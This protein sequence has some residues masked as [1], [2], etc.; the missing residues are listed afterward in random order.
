MSLI[1][2]LRDASAPAVA[3]EIAAHRVSA[4]TLEIRGGQPVVAAHAAEPLLAGALIP[5]P[6]SANVLDRPA[7]VSAI[8]RLFERMGG[9]PRRVGLV[10]P[11]LVA[12]V[13]LVRLEQ[14]PTRALDREQL[15][16]WQVRKTLPFPIEEAQVTFVP[17][18]V[19]DEWHEFIVSIARRTVIEEYEQ[20]CAAVGAHAGLVDL[21]TFSVINAVLAGGSP[22]GDWLLLHVASDSASVAIVRGEH[23]IV[24]RCRPADDD[25]TLADV[26][27]QTAMYYEDRL[28]G[29]GFTRVLLAHAG[30]ETANVDEIRRGLEERLGVAVAIVDPRSAA[31]LTDRISANP[32]LLETLAPLV[33]LLLRERPVAHRGSA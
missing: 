17:G 3:I 9:R 11:D 16:R 30:L 5:S 12:K 23:L 13:S 21:S 7:V 20:L 6:T 8:G 27:H 25:V 22:G 4:A 28:K 32:V 19:T 29:S 15:V 33:G 26:V 2:A 18:L 24:F 10:V 1:D 14:V 31:A